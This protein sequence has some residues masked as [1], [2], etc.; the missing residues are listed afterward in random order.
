M[1]PRARGSALCRRRQEPARKRAVPWRVLPTLLLWLAAAQ[2]HAHAVLLDTEPAHRAVLAQAPTR[3]VLRFNEAV[4]PISLRVLDSAGRA[5]E[6]APPRAVD[7]EVAAELPPVLADG[8]YLV[9]YRVTSADGHP[10]E[11][12]ILFAV[13]AV[14]E[15]WSGDTAAHP[16]AAPW[17]TAAL[18]TRAVY[19]LGL[20]VAA[21]GLLFFAAVARTPHAL[22]RRWMSA[23]AAVAALAGVAG[24]YLHGAALAGDGDPRSAL[25]WRAVFAGPQ[26]ASATAALSGLAVAFLAAPH[27]GAARAR[28]VRMGGALLALAGTAVT[29][30]SAAAGWMWWPVAALHLVAAGFWLGSL[31]PLLRALMALR[32]AD[33]AALLQR[34]SRV[35]APTVAALALAG[36]ALALERLDTLSDLLVTDYGRL[37]LAKIAGAI[38]LV[39]LAAVNKLRLTPAIAAGASGAAARLRFSIAAE[40]ALMAGVVGLAAALAHTDPHA[41]HVHEGHDRHAHHRHHGPGERQAEGVT[42]RL[43]AGERIA[44][45]EIYPARRGRNTLTASFATRAGGALAPLEASLELALPAAGV[46]PFGIKLAPLGQG[47]FTAEI[48]E[49]ALVGRWRIRLDALVGEFEKVIFRGEVEIR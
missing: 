15:R 10:V 6:I 1:G 2:A 31:P 43:E 33:G 4:T 41:G 29:G 38:L 11:G 40:L 7:R 47:K 28:F 9:S 19:M 30:H 22:E 14:P 27:L 35:A 21:G 32:P 37:V 13:G 36:L 18:A 26:W 49:F 25:F 23:A 24:V 12:A 34:F 42:L 46:G 39:A 17:R 5:I 44:A 8:T 20:F 45:V 48:A 16:A 3:V